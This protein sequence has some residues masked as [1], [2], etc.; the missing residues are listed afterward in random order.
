MGTFRFLSSPKGFHVLRVLSFLRRFISSLDRSRNK[1]CFRLRRSLLLAI[2]FLLVVAMLLL[3]GITSQVHAATLTGTVCLN[4]P[5]SADSTA[6]CAPSGTSLNGPSPSATLTNP[7]P[8]GSVRG[9]TQIRVGVYL[10]NSNQTN[11]FDITVLADHTVLTPTAVDLTG[12]ILPPPT[13]VI[14]ECAGGSLVVGPTCL[15]TDTPDTL[16]FAVS[17]APG[18]LSTTGTGLLFTA[19]Y[20]ITGTTPTAGIGIGFQTGCGTPDSPTS[21]PPVCVTITNGLA[22]PLPENVATVGF[23]N[24]VDP[25]WVAISTTTPTITFNLGAPSPL[26]KINATAENGYPGIVGTDSVSF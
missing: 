26:A 15:G 24:S 16:H 3:P 4:D 21:D 11:G 9:P 23:N 17:A 2:P 22:A 12:S 5:S 14:V 1:G 20:N 6:P 7:L 8:P 18:A 25:N 10:Y 13:T 19:I